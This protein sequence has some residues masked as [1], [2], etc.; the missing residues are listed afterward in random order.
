MAIPRDGSLLHGAMFP[1][2]ADIFQKCMTRLDFA[3]TSSAQAY[4]GHASGGPRGEAVGY[5]GYLIRAVSNLPKCHRQPSGLERDPNLV[6]V[7]D[8]DGGDP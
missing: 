7:N 1:D 5:L 3:Q 2:R 6:L 4:R 8:H